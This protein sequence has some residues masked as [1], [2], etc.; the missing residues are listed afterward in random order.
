MTNDERG[1]RQNDEARM[2]KDEGM[3][4]SEC[5][6]G[7]AIRHPS[8]GFVS[9]FSLFSDSPD[10][11]EDQVQLSGFHPQLSRFGF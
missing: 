8:L 9:S 7:S 4:K 11:R 6:K 3:T 2:T 1:I 5:R 10:F